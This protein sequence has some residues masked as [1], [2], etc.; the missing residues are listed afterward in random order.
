MCC[1]VGL[2]GYATSITATVM[3]VAEVISSYHVARRAVLPDE[4]E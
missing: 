3:P 2:M 1:L 4:Q